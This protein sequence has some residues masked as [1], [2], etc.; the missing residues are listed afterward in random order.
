M[1]APLGWP[2]SL[3]RTLN[4]HNAGAVIE[5]EPNM[6]FRRETDR[7]IYR[8]FRKMPLDVGADR[9]ARTAVAALQ[10]LDRV[11]GRTG[12]V[13]PLSWSPDDKHGVSAI[14]VYPAGT[15]LAYGFPASGYKKSEQ[16]TVRTDILG[17]LS[18]VLDLPADTNSLLE[19]AD[20]LD[21][22]VCVMAAFDFMK[23]RA[24]PPSD[25]LVAKNEGWIWVREHNYSS[26]QIKRNE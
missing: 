20:K 18:E 3:G 1:D 13:I 15:L 11:R 26:S 4:Q 25:L 2:E 8:R 21:A 17:R 9:I 22:I 5:T 16:R 6:L 23:H 14:E 24:V 7:D 10:L 12:L 19:D